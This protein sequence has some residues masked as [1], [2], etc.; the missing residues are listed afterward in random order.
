[1]VTADSEQ[2]RSDERGRELRSL[3]QQRS[4]QIQGFQQIIQS[5]TSH[6]AEKYLTI[7]KREQTMHCTKR[8]NI[9][10]KR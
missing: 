6:L 8:S 4:R 2:D 5:Q 7:T 3:R 10:R 1:M 9:D